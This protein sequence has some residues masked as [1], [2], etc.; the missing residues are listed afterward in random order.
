[1]T[2]QRDH[3]AGPFL[4]V[5]SQSRS[6]L[7]T[8]GDKDTM[9]FRPQHRPSM[10]VLRALEDGKDI[11]LTRHIYGERY[12]IGREEGDYLVGHDGAISAKHVEIVRRH[13]GA[14]Y[15]WFLKDLGSTNGTFV[16]VNKATLDH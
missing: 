9:P 10:A 8:P 5:P 15:H 13:D 12:V 6:T 4:E 7:L 2:S 14:R 3:N 1:M 11:G 16:R